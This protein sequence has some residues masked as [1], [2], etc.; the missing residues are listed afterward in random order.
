MRKQIVCKL[1]GVFWKKYYEGN[2]TKS[3]AILI[4]KEIPRFVVNSTSSYSI[5]EPIDTIIIIVSENNL[6]FCTT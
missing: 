1:S 6:F 3:L 5:K 4:I 2:G